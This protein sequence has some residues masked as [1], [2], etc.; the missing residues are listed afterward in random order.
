MRSLFVDK[1]RWSE[2]HEGVAGRF[3]NDSMARGMLAGMEK[4]R[5]KRKNK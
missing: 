1:I 2:R 4:A 5:E 3:S